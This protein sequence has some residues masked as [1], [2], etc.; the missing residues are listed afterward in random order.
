MRTVFVGLVFAMCSLCN[1]SDINLDFKSLPSDQEGWSYGGS[2]HLYGET[3]VCWVSGDV[4]TMNTMGKGLNRPGEN[5]GGASYTR[6]G[7]LT[8]APFM[9]S[10]HARCLDEEISAWWIPHTFAMSVIINNQNFNVVLGPD[11]LSVLKGNA[12]PANIYTFDNT[13]YHNYVLQATPG[14]SSYT[15][16]VD[17]TDVF[18]GQA[19][20]ETLEDGIRFGDGASTGN[21]HVEITALS[22]CQPYPPENTA[23]VANAGFDQEVISSNGTDAPATLDGSASSDPDEGDA[24]ESYSWSEDGIVIVTGVNPTIPLLSIGV[25]T[26]QLIVNDGSV[27]SES[28]S[29]EINVITTGQAAR[30]LAELVADVKAQVKSLE[31]AAESFDKGNIGAGINQL[32][33]FQNKV[34]AQSGKKI[35]P[36][37]AQLLVDAAQKIIDAA[38]G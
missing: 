21:V 29:V 4:L 32:Q 34:K 9:L 7:A 8:T 24:L 26:I 13:V 31:A 18:V 35:D 23:P 38:E 17:E 37:D 33:A 12:A 16:T 20:I 30:N 25:H 15:L 27:D 11:K 28:D 10:F 6:T 1:G 3:E 19:G 2:P 36:A 5:G 14:I 22:F